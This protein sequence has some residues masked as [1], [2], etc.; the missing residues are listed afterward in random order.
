MYLDFA[1]QGLEKA[2]DKELPTEHIEYIEKTALRNAVVAV[3]ARHKYVIFPSFLPSFY[4]IRYFIQLLYH[5]EAY[6]FCK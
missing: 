6:D 3:V 1:H 5:Q 4:I 2:I